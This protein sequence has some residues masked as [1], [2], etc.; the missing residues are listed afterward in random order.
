MTRQHRIGKHPSKKPEDRVVALW[1]DDDRTDP[2]EIACPVECH[3][4]RLTLS[5]VPVVDRTLD[6]REDR[7]A[8]A[9]RYAH[10]AAVCLKD[11]STK[12]SD[13][14]GEDDLAL[15]PANRTA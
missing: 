11:V 2:I 4:V 1:R 14:L 10:H 6:G 15:Q 7:S 13:V 3:A 8:V 12:Y 5:G 9:W